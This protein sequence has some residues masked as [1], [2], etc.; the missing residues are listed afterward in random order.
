MRTNVPDGQ[1][2]CRLDVEV[3]VGDWQTLSMFNNV[4]QANTLAHDLSY[5]G[6]PA[7][8]SC[9][10]GDYAYGECEMC[11]NETLSP[12]TQEGQRDATTE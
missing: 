3:R 2:I 1:M 9:K 8:V 10:C 11:A 7:M 6:I 12:R 4:A 5:A